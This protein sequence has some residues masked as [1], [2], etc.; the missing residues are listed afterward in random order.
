MLAST[1]VDG[2]LVHVCEQDNA[3]GSTHDVFN[4]VPGDGYLNRIFD[5]NT[6][7]TMMKEFQNRI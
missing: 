1:V 5:D 6:V 4:F 3:H 2:A 7:F